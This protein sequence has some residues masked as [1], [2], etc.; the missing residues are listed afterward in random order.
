MVLGIVE[1]AV[2][3]PINLIYIHMKVLVSACLLGLNTRYDGKS[4]E[5]Q[6]VI[7]YLQNKNI[8][9]Y[10][11]CAEQLGGLSTPREPSEIEEGFTAKDVINGK[12]KV[13]TKSLR[14]V[15]KEFLKGAN[16]VLDFCK[17]FNITHAILQERSPSCGYTKVYDGTFEGTL[18]DGHGIL[19]QLLIDNGI[20]IIDNLEG[21]K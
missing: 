12:A 2:S 21:L 19:T 7:Q 11:L 6:T 8:D 14:D 4:T 5:D 15:T 1:I 9:F 13:L 17:R 16:L 10:P 18:K 3:I 20:Q